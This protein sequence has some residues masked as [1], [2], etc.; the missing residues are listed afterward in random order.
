MYNSIMNNKGK[1]GAIIIF[2]GLIFATGFFDGV[3]AQTA[4][5][6]GEQ[7]P[8]QQMLDMIFSIEQQL[9]AK[10][11]NIQNFS[12]QDLDWEVLLKNA[13]P[14][15]PDTA[16]MEEEMR[17]NMMQEFSSYLQNMNNN[18]YKGDFSFDVNP[19]NPNPNT[20]VNINLMSNSFD[21]NRSDI[22][23]VV[24]NNT[25]LRGIGEKEFNFLTGD[26]GSK[27]T[28]AILVTSQKGDIFSKT[29]N[30]SPADIDVLWESES[31]VPFFYKGK[32]LSSQGSLIKITA[33]PNFLKGGVKIPYSEL[34]YDWQVNYQKIS[35]ASGRGKQSMYFV[36]SKTGESDIVNVVVS[37][38]NKSIRVEKNIN[39]EPQNPK[40]VFYKENLLEGELYNQAIDEASNDDII[41]AEPYFFSNNQTDNLSYEWFFNKNNKIESNT[42]KNKIKISLDSNS[43]V[44]ISNI[45]VKILNKINMFQS[46]DKTFRINLNGD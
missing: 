43:P 13:I 18:Y 19:K 33:I 10:G 1:I 35:N 2:C 41:M 16:K 4:G 3:Y 11:E 12:L 40:V 44:L 20:N 15:I 9:K 34:F 32:A 14:S 39:I 26:I 8:N 38:F 7:V 25:K 30:F 5:Q 42:D 24:N 21:I 31:Y 22:K 29:I 46:A 37:D 23:W 36:S 27:T 6:Q 28:V 17:N 45:Y